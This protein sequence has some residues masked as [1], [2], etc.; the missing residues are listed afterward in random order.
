[1]WEE[2]LWV[3]VEQ[4]GVRGARLRGLGL[5]PGLRGFSARAGAGVRGGVGQEEGV[6]CQ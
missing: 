2:E 5:G 6:E 1:M 4:V 3:W